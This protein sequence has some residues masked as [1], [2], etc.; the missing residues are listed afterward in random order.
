MNF[1][2]TSAY[3]YNDSKIDFYKEE[4]I[5]GTAGVLFKW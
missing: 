1:F 5:L 3:Y 4:V 2:I